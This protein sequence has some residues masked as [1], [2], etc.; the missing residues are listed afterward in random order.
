MHATVLF[1]L[2][3]ALTAGAVGWCGARV[4]RNVSI[5]RGAH[6]VSAPKAA[7]AAE[8]FYHQQFYTDE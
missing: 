6:A 8:A 3:H 1:T 4:L 5:P 2:Y 7:R